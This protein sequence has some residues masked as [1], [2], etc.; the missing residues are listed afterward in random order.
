MHVPLDETRRRFDLRYI[1][2]RHKVQVGLETRL[3]VGDKDVRR[4]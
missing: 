4:K 2:T 3:L 1:P